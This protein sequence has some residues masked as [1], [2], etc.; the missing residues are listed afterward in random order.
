MKL[1]FIK[2]IVYTKGKTLGV[3]FKNERTKI[4][5]LTKEQVR[6]IDTYLKEFEENHVLNEKRKVDRIELINFNLL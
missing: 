6:N 4:Q 2:Y 1:Y 5:D 3:S